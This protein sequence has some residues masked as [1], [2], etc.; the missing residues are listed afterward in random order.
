MTGIGQLTDIG[1]LDRF[2]ETWPTTASIKFVARGKQRLPRDNINIDARR[3][4]VKI[5]TC[6]RMLGATLLGY[7]V[8]LFAKRRNGLS[9]FL[10]FFDNKYSREY[11]KLDATSIML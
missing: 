11:F 5:L 4:S 6:T 10:V 3:F 1:C 8:L 7:S 2:S 9:R